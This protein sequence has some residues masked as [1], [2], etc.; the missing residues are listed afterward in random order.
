MHDNIV[1]TF[2]GCRRWRNTVCTI[3]LLRTHETASARQGGKL[4]TTARTTWKWF[5]CCFNPYSHFSVKFNFTKVRDWTVIDRR[6][7]IWFVM[8]LLFTHHLVDKQLH[9]SFVIRCRSVVNIGGGD[10]I[11]VIWR[12]CC[13]VVPILGIYL[14][15]ST[16]AWK[17]IDIVWIAKVFD[18]TFSSLCLRLGWWPR[19]GVTTATTTSW[20]NKQRG[21]A[22]K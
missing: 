18:A 12:N 15:V 10:F 11:M 6:C 17:G 8:Y 14:S 3:R 22:S 16:D 20:Y 19:G 13:D 21:R 1:G 9:L 2:R 5:I 7:F 4:R